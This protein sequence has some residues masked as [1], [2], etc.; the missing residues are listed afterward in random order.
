MSVRPSEVAL[1]L[2]LLHRA[3]RVGVDHPSLALA[4]LGAQ[5]LEHDRREVVGVALDRAGQRVA[6]EGPEPDLL[7]LD[8]L[9]GINR[10]PV[11]V[12]HHQHPV[13]L[14]HGTLG[15]EVERHDRD[16]L[17]VD[18]LPDIELGPVRER[19]HADAL[20]RVL[21]AVVEVPELGAL[22]LGVPAV[23]RG[24]E[25]EHTLLGAGLLLVPAGA[26][27]RDIEPV[28]IEC[29]LQGLGLHDVGVERGAVVQ[30]VDVLLD[31]LGVDVDQQ[32]HPGLLGHVVPEVVHRLE[33][34]AG[35]DVQE[36]EGRRARVERL[37]GQVQHHRRV[38][39]D[40]V[41]HHRVLGLRHHLP[42]DVHRLGLEPV[43]VGQVL[44]AGELVLPVR[45]QGDLGP[46]V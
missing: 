36:R 12:D 6:A 11:V 40:R 1:L 41:Q 20:A 23:R 14:D 35:V 2:L 8:L 17:P 27:E 29:L 9:V 37:P 42:D 45:G 26:A 33:L 16:L 19:E 21:A 22:V 18:V 5:E 32:I 4:G 13:A 15:R 28:V 39:P 34:P 24:P 38:L 43:E 31:P 46:P 7:D 3:G 25:R 44:A 10:Q 30:W